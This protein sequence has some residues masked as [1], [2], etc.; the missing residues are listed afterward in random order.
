[1]ELD[2]VLLLSNPQ[3]MS[4]SR[5]SAATLK[6]SNMELEAVLLLSSFRT[7]DLDAVLLLSRSRT[8]KLD[9]VLLLS[10]SRTMDW[11]KC[12]YSQVIELWS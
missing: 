11:I 7:I 6:F 1:M 8:M 5:C 9:A 2:A 3:T 12:S 4:S 10:S